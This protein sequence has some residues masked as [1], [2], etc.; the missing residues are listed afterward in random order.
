MSEDFAEYGWSKSYKQ[1]NDNASEQPSV[2]VN[3]RRNSVLEKKWGAL[4]MDDQAHEDLKNHKQEIIRQR[5]T[6]LDSIS[7]GFAAETDGDAWKERFF[8]L[9]PL[10][11]LLMKPGWL[12][13]AGKLRTGLV[14]AL[15]ARADLETL[16]L[17]DCEHG[18]ENP[19]AMKLGK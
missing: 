14:S 18:S 10:T 4:S 3:R 6:V 2:S 11:H 16:S 17:E 13:S 5:N 15:T 19:T 8:N 12:G 9:K 1:W 7:D